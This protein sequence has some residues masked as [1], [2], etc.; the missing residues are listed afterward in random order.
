MNAAL[1]DFLQHIRHEKGQSIQTQK[2][3][4]TLL[5]R[6]VQWAESNGLAEWAA[7]N[8]KHLTE[9]LKNERNR[10]PQGQGEQGDQLSPESVYLQI[11]ALRAFYHFAASEEIVSANIAENLS[12]PRRWKRLP[13]ALSDIDIEKLLQAPTQSSA[14]ELCTTAILE[15]AYASGLRLAELRNLRLEQLHL[16]DG[17]VTVV[18][19]GNK[20]RMVPLGEPAIEAIKHY[21][22]VGRPELVKSRSP[23]NVFLTQRGTSFAQNTMWARIKTR[24]NRSGI[25]RNVTPHMLRH[26]FATHLMENGADLRV[27]QELLG[28]ACISTTEVYTHVAGK[29]LREVHDQ[30]H[31]RA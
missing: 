9:F 16:K 22:Q 15:L 29:R 1:E 4:A 10:K 17:F 30:Y 5:G 13:K 24:V 25:K 21:L 23:A 14:Y 31:P 19:K 20:E 28:L 6:F 12:L 2:T 26:S 7:V 18:G 3:Y 8:R 11:A 27:I